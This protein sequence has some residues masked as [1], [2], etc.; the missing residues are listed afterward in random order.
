M[1][2]DIF[3]AYFPIELNIYF[4]TTT[5][6]FTLLTLALFSYALKLNNIR[7]CQWNHTKQNLQ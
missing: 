2:A 7:T 1:S 5:W 6:C 4:S 3:M